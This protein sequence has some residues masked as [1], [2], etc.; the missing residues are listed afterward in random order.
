M[1][2]YMLKLAVTWGFMERNPASGIRRLQE[3]NKRT[4]YLSG[5]ELKRFLAAVDAEKNKVLAMFILFLLAT[6]L[7]K[8]EVRLALKANLDLA[9]RTLWLPDTKSGEGRTVVLN[10]LAISALKRV[11]LREG[12]PYLF[13]GRKLGRPVIDPKATFKAILELSK[14]DNLRLHDLRHTFCSLAVS[15][16]A[17]LYAV[18]HLVG[19]KSSITTQRYAHLQDA[20]LR[21]VSGQVAKVLQ[22]AFA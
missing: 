2:H 17:S 21:E 7:R 3:N 10:D 9:Q 22:E 15:K 1:I 13:P 8:S 18:Q 6:G 14:I 4:R 11:P 5:E 12:N 20:T 19:H 16:G